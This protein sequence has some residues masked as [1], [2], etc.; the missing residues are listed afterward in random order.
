MKKL[1]L[2]FTLLCYGTTTTAQCYTTL[3]GYDFKFYALKTDGTLWIK[4]FNTNDYFGLGTTATIPD[5]IQFGSDTNWTANIVQSL[6]F[7]LAIKTDGSLWSWGTA[8]AGAG[9]G[10]AAQNSNAPYTQPTQ[11]GTD[12]NWAKIVT[13]GQHTLAIKTNGTL[14]VWGTNA[15]G[16]F[17]IPSFPIGAVSYTP[18]Q[19]GIDTDW[20]NVY[21]GNY[22]SVGVSCAI[23]T[24]GTLWTWGGN[25][26]RIGY[27]NAAADD[28]FRSPHQVGTDTWKA[29]AV[30]GSGI[31][32]FFGIKTDG[33]L[34][35]WGTS[36][37]N[38]NTYYFGNGIQNYSSKNP[39]QIG[40]AND[41]EKI[42][43]Q[44]TTIGLKISG[45]LWGWGNNTGYQLGLGTGNNSNI[46]FPT[47][48]GTDTDWNAIHVQTGS[49]S[50]LLSL[51][52][53]NSIYF[54][55]YY[56]PDGTLNIVPTLFSA[57]Q[58]TLS[59][60]DFDQSLFVALSQPVYRC[61]NF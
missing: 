42:V 2:I 35:G 3:I 8:I 49:G 50:S 52:N 51:K 41:W 7:T 29:A 13:S 44:F 11:L 40:T 36:A 26:I 31:P 46:G 4:G 10:T 18:L 56:N 5:F 59:V 23:K 15:N 39:E 58:C 32:M 38:T 16:N 22:S 1:L 47:Q 57:T 54:S 33:T 60:E 61:C 12:T 27:P 34:W 21:A 20:Q 45:A 55:G 19:V 14:W 24:N 28:S 37:S 25:G 30:A 53:N 17:G 6:S 9:G 43:S 48:I